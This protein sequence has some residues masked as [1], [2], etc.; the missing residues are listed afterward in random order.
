MTTERRF[1]N[2]LLGCKLS[3][4][5]VAAVCNDRACFLRRF[6]PAGLDRIDPVCSAEPT[7][8]HVKIAVA[9]RAR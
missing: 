8:V 6:R 7:E 3:G 2:S 1:A 4:W 5:P 9:Q